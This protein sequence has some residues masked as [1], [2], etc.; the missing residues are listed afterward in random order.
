MFFEGPEKKVELGLHARGQDLRAAGRAFWEARV[1]EAGAVIL[2]EIETEAQIAY[3]LSESSL[4][5]FERRVVMITCG[6]TTLVTAAE[7]MLDAF[8]RDLEY[9]VFERKNEHFPEYQPSGFLDDARKLAR[10]VPSDAWR[11][12]TPDGHRIQMLAS[13]APIGDGTADRTLEI[14]MHGIHPDAAAVFG[15]ARAQG[16]RLARFRSLFDGFTVDEHFFEPAGYSMNAIRGPHYLTVH[17]TPEDIASYVSFET[18][19]D[20]G[21]DPLPWVERVR[22]VF[23]PRS[24]DVM[25]FAPRRVRDYALEGHNVVSWTEKALPSG[26]HVAYRHFE[27]ARRAPETAFALPL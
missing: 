3:L 13:R 16:E 20:F 7:S 19:L 5:V 24:L 4:F 21:E 25:T 23:E 17:V 27:Q 11:F 6:R 22:A 26:F 1:K 12:G 15:R 18:N 8:G 2:S 14:L 9:L 10:R